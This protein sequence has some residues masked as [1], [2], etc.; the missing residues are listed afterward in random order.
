[1][2]KMD[3]QPAVD[4]TDRMLTDAVIQSGSED[5]FRELYRRH[6]PRLLGFVSR[7]LA[8]TDAEAEDVVQETWLRACQALD[9]FRW[10]S[11]FSTW[12]LGIG[13]NVARDHMRKN[14]RSAEISMENLPDPP[15]PVD[16]PENRIDLERSIELLPDG[17]R[18]VLILH[19]VEGMKHEDIANVLDISIG[20]TKS[21]LSRARHALRVLL[22]EAKRGGL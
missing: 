14:A 9:R 13:A 21:Q 19:D 1:M 16:V 17:Y 18:T 10:D 5:A 8:R 22:A 11:V 20:T 12:L 6:T 3:A 15:G 4:L 7:F 2:D